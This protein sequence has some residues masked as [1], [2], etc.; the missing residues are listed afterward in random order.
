MNE[1]RDGQYGCGM[2]DMDICGEGCGQGWRIW[3]NMGNFVKYGVATK[4]GCRFRNE[5]GIIPFNKYGF[6]AL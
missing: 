5:E 1:V 3:I 6:D 2:G 4:G